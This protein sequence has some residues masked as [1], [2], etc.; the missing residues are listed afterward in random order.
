MVSTTVGAVDVLLMDLVEFSLVLLQEEFAVFKV[1]VTRADGALG[2]HTTVVS[3]VAESAAVAADA[4]SRPF[5]FVVSPLDDG[6]IEC[7]DLFQ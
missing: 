6:V 2:W 3:S 5:G 7:S 1:V 4:Y